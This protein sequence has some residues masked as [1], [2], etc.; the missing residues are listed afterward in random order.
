[1]NRARRLLA[2]EKTANGDYENQAFIHRC[3][4]WPQIYPKRQRLQPE[5]DRVV[6]QRGLRLLRLVNGEATSNLPSVLPRIVAAC[7][8]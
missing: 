3:R 2:A 8:V 4:R 7:E 5:R 1:M 6:R